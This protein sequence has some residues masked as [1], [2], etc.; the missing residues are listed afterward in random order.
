MSNIPTQI[1]PGCNEKRLDFSIGH[2]NQICAEE[3]VA[4]AQDAY[5]DLMELWK[6]ERRALLAA[7]EKIKRLEQEIELSQSSKS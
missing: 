3:H 2:C 6:M 5:D 7:K 1:C 4:R